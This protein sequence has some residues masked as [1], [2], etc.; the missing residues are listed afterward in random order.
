MGKKGRISQGCAP[1][2]RMSQGCVTG[3]LLPGVAVEPLSGG[4]GLDQVPLWEQGL[5]GTV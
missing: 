1:E 3:V 2:S 5:S 4:T